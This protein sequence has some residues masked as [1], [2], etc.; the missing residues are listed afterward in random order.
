MERMK[1]RLQAT[2]PDKT[3][4]TSPFFFFGFGA[5]SIRSVSRGSESGRMK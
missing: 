1:P 3:E 5:S 4:R 2:E